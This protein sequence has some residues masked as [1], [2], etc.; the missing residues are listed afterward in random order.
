MKNKK[1]LIALV[2][3]L[4][5]G[6]MHFVY[7]NRLEHRLSGGKKIAVLVTAN[8]LEA[9]EIITRSNLA[10]RVVPSICVDK[11]MVLASKSKDVL[12]LATETDLEAD[13]TIQWTD[14]TER[15]NPVADDLAKR[16]ESGQRAMTIQ[17]NGTLSMG[18][19]LK[20][21]HRVDIMGTFAR[22]SSTR[23]D[24]V[25]VT[26]LQNLS[27]LAT[28]KNLVEPKRS[29]KTNRFATVTLSV[30]LEEAEILSLAT[31]KGTLSLVLRG[32]QDLSIVRNVPEKRM[33]DIWEAGKRNAV[34]AQK[35]VK[36]KPLT[37]E[38]IKVR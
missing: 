7:V 16:I 12:K 17:V 37:I 34:Q 13:Q 27:V 9:G 10:T 5:G 36:T 23:G 1:W 11:R 24:K 6:T 22:E 25:T 33:A 2:L 4:I 18:G 3:G 19:M 30:G 32:H 35:A 21:G 15:N 28:G 29:D 31:T 26:L 20:P 38:R 14:F 8:A